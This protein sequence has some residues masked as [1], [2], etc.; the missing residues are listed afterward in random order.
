V[1]S[2]VFMNKAQ[3][4]LRAARLLLDNGYADDACN[5]AY[6]AMFDG[7][8]AAL[9]VVGA[10]VQAEEARTHRGLIS[11]F[12]QYV[13][14]PG[15]LPAGFGKALNRA[16]EVRLLADYSGEPVEIEQAAELVHGA[17]EFI[18]AVVALLDGSPSTP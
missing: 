11:A 7:A 13:V 1:K 17:T 5:R 6:Y 4:A 10:P 3:S 15:R 18:T 12:G 14:K 16:H 9:L 8:R 2:S